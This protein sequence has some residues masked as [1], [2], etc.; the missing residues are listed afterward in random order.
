MRPL[1]TAALEHDVLALNRLGGVTVRSVLEPMSG[2]EPAPGAVA[3]RLFFEE[4]KSSF[5]LATDNYGSRYVGPEET[6]FTYSTGNTLLPYDNVSASAIK[7]LHFKELSYLATRYDVPLFEEGLLFSASGSLGTTAPGDRLKR[8]A[9]YNHSYDAKAGLSW[10]A[11]SQRDERLVFDA[12]LG[13]KHVRSVSLSQQLYDDNLRELRS[14]LTYETSD[15]WNGANIV[16]GELVAGLPAFGASNAQSTQLSR[17]NGHSTF[18]KVTLNLSRVQ[19]IGSE[20]QLYAAAT[21]QLAD[22]TLLTSE[23]FSYGGQNFGR[24]YDSSEILGDHGAAGA[25]ELR[26]NGLPRK[27]GIEPQLFTFYDI[28]KAWVQ[29]K[30]GI[31]SSGSSA[32]IGLRINTDIHATVNLTLAQPLTRPVAAAGPHDG[33]TPRGFFS[34]TF[35]F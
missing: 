6:T 14:A 13:I 21:G 19:N 11:V 28:G 7:S 22:R 1:Q 9:L 26:Y 5:L 32:G 35:D 27:A 2:T 31:A 18:T 20:F 10:E 34:V 3:V 30:S 4:K 23:E 8:Y 16:N 12:G 29:N 33:Y 25:L 15:M 24:A 17:R